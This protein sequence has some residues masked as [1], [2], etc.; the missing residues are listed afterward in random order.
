MYFAYEV[1]IR[2]SSSRRVAGLQPSLKNLRQKISPHS[3]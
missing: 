2:G 3:P 1:G